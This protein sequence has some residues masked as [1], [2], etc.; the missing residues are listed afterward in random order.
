MMSLSR[1][2]LIMAVVIFVAAESDA[3]RDTLTA[4]QKDRLGKIQR[5]LVETVAIT[6]QGA[7]DP[8]PLTDTIVR[9]MQGLG[10]TVVTDPTQP[11]DVVLRVKCEQHKTWEGTAASGGDADVPDSP[12]RVWKGPACQLLYLL[13][14][15]KLGWHKEVRTEFLDARQAATA[16]HVDN[17]SAFALNKLIERLEEYHFPVLL[18]AEWGQV[19]RLLKRLDESTVSP[20]LKAKIIAQLGEMFATEAVP[21]LL[22]ALKDPDSTIAKAAAQALGNI[23]QK[24]SISALVSVLQTGKPELQAAAAKGLGQ[25]G[26]LHGDF[27]IIPPLLD[28]LKSDHLAVKTEAAWALGKLP[29]KRSYEP[30]YALYRT[31]Q[32]SGIDGQ[33]RNTEQVQKLKEALN[34]SLKQVDTFDQFN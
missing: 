8:G 12:S 34:W 10:Y 26:A 29:D 16:A 32:T 23:G 6:D 1:H 33:G 13:D 15:K 5:V 17:A 20:A 7:T 4:G 18:A 19:D 27:S 24:D 25:V 30:I 31:L 14:G 2:F 3:R 9:R 28:A 21:R 22:T 11:Y